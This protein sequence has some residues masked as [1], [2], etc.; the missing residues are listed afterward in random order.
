[1]ASSVGW[2]AV[3][4]G[5][6]ESS[7][8]LIRCRGCKTKYHLNCAGL[9]SWPEDIVAWRCNGC[10]GAEKKSSAVRSRI[11]AVRAAHKALRASSA[12]FYER[13]K[14]ALKPFVAEEALAKLA[15]GGKQK[16][17][18]V[19]PLIIGPS[20]PYINATLRAYQVDGVNWLLSQYAV[21]TGGILGDEMG[22]GKTKV[23]GSPTN[24]R[25]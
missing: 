25:P 12:A 9:R 19:A 14:A 21:G 1:M 5:D 20:E 8:D 17:T 11:L 2:C 23:Y 6:A 16:L 3:C 15:S 4:R 22:L 10:E 13:S 7:D 24:R 18:K